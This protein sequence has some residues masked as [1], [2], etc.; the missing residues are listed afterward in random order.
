MPRE[1]NT[2]LAVG[3]DHMTARRIGSRTVA[4]ARILGS[5]VEPDGRTVYWLDRHLIT[6]D[7]RLPDG[8]VATGAISTVLS[9]DPGH[10]LP[11]TMA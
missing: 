6:L 8:V 1:S 5:R 9:V 7:M 11:G 3:Q 4:T 10:A 2:V